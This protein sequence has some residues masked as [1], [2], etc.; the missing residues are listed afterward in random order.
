MKVLIT[1]GA[2]FIGGNLSARLIEGGHEV[3]AFDNLVQGNRA[4][5]PDSA[6]FIEGDIRDY[7]SLLSATKGCQAVI[8]LAANFANQ[9]SVDDPLTDL[10]INGS[11][12][13]NALEAARISECKRFVYASSSCVYGPFDGVLNEEQKLN[14]E[15]PY[16][17]SKLLGEHYSRFYAE[18]HGLSTISLRLFNVYGPLDRPGE[19][20][21]VIPNYFRSAMDGNALQVMG[22]GGSDSRDYTFI[23]DCVECFVRAL[24][25]EATGVLNVGGG[26]E[27]T[28]GEL[29]ELVQE[30]SG[31]S[32]GI[33]KV[34][35]RSWDHIKRRVADTKLL[36]ETLGFKPLVKI[37]DG[38]QR[39]WE[40]FE[41]EGPQPI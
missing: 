32:V 15:T 13:L 21:N 11:G 7:D 5:L 17:M 28:I 41:S 29:A 14:P 40:W 38:L 4:N 22:D 27:V 34:E 8:H 3:V 20:R 12:T 16:A 23:D 39:T 35:K 37:K 2:G 33:E 26:S 25:S 9:R 18:Q 24:N 6:E 36:E 19:Y 10:A 1:G 30:A 31:K